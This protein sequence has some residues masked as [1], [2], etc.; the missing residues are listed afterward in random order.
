[1][2]GRTFKAVC[3]ALAL[4][5]LLSGCTFIGSKNK[6]SISGTTLAG[7]VTGIKEKTVTLALGFITE[8]QGADNTS[9]SAAATPAP[10]GDAVATPAPTEGVTA[11]APKVTDESDQLKAQQS[12]QSTAAPEATAA[13]TGEDAETET[14]DT[15]EK[16]VTADV[17]TFT[18]GNSVATLELND[19]T[20][21]FKEDGTAAAPTD[22]AV[23]GILEFTLDADGAL[24]KIVIR[25]IPR[26][27]TSQ[28]VRYLVASEYS[29]DT[30]LSGDTIK[31]TAA[32][33]NAVIVD[34][35]AEVGF[36]SVTVSRA[37]SDTA[38]DAALAAAR[39]YGVGA[40]LLTAEGKSYIRKSTVTT[41]AA[42]AAGLFSYSGGKI[43]AADTSVTTKQAS[44]PGLGVTGGGKLY[45]FDMTVETD[46]AKA[47]ALMSGLGGGKLVASGGL[48]TTNGA[49]APAVVSAGSAAVN[50]ATVTA[51]ASGAAEV[52]GGSSLNIFDSALTGSMAA[53]GAAPA[54]TVLVCQDGS[55]TAEDGRG[56]YKMVGGTLESKSGGLIFTTNTQSDI[57][58]SGVKLTQAKD[59][60]Y[61]LRC[62]GNSLWGQTG[63]NGAECTFTASAQEMTGDVIWDSIS[64]LNFY[65]TDGSKLTGSVKD[66]ESAAGHSKGSGHCD[67][68]IG[69]DSTWV[70]T[71]NSTLSA[72]YS[73]GKI[74][75]TDGKTVTVKDAAG[76][77]LVRGTSKFVVTVDSYKDSVD[78][79]GALS[80]PKWADY[81]VTRPSGM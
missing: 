64:S 61:F 55:G 48:Y 53:D 42:G 32:E 73:E 77:R 11:V 19:E 78:L 39:N 67:M 49:E 9:A 58:L 2:K 72:L 34:D 56:T 63:G 8:P 62:T 1:M 17:A 41:D 31:S 43:Y 47:P 54:W 71:G 15:G 10:T 37:N 74:V 13:P 24:T 27:I 5:V 51:N 80:V 35:G 22:I 79:S 65:L 60:P 21:L 76:K 75:D 38:G 52:L 44:S 16:G 6:L 36:D 20:M 50:G 7:Q 66:D 59:S 33:E 45:V 26:M 3:A 28:G 69:E 14:E 46:G 68:Y 23:G 12:T 25:S 30:E 70:V 81:Q 4:T 57:L 29:A 18:L 40:A